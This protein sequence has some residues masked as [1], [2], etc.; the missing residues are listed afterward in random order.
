MIP[1]ALTAILA[2]MV[3]FWLP[4]PIGVPL[5]LF[6]LYG[7]LKHSTWAR[8]LMAATL[9]KSHRAKAIYRQIMKLK[10]IATDRLSRRKG[11]SRYMNE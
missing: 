6:G 4:I 3:T 10:R 2:G 8:Q 9:R 11:D 5:L 1:I 7:L